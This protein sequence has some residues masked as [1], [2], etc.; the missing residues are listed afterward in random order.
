MNEDSKS[1]Y[2]TWPIALAA[3]GILAVIGFGIAK[4]KFSGKHTERIDACNTTFQVK[5]DVG[6]NSGSADFTAENDKAGT[7][8]VGRATYDGHKWTPDY[9]GSA[10]KTAEFLKSRAEKEG[11]VSLTSS[12][13]KGALSVEDPKGCL[14][15][16]ASKLQ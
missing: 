13:L 11:Y 4:Y 10:E 2:H 14:D 5:Y 16:I 3:A 6:V 7:I 8:L 9:I 15:D 12:F 1:N